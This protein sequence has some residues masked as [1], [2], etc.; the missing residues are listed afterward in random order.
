MPSPRATPTATAWTSRACS[1]RTG[2]R[3]ML[4]FMPPSARRVLDLGCGTGFFLA[5]LERERPGAVGLDI[6]HDMLR[7]SE[8]YVPGARADHRRRRDAALRRRLLRRDLLQG[9]PAPHARPRRLPVEVPPRALAGRRD[10][11]RGAL[12]RQLP[13]PLGARRALL[14][15]PATSTSATRASRRRA[16]ASSASAP[17][18]RSWPRAATASSPTSSAAS[19]TTSAS[20][21]TS[22]RTR[23]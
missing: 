9:L 3:E 10:D 20:S 13:D 17:A 19:P 7:V 16:C 15:Q 1:R 14:L 6:S 12:Q 8:Q 21:S 23:P 5:E 4:S 22:R 18:S 2:T 11:P